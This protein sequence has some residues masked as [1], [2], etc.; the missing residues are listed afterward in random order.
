MPD[1]HRRLVPALAVVVLTLVACDGGRP[2]DASV[3]SSASPDA[4]SVD[5]AP[6]IAALY[7]GNAPSPEEADESDCFGDA[8]LDR[9]GGTDLEAAGIVVDGAVV[10]ALPVLDADTAT[11]WVQ[12]QHECIDFVEVSTR[13]LGAQS[14][15][16]VAAGAYADCLRAA[17]T[18]AEVDAA[19]VDTLTGAFDTEAVAALGRAQADCARSASPPD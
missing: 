16:R 11:Q 3:S 15:G 13:A 7:A 1:V 17:L 2:D 14:K 18:G 6:G 5:L 19:L 10:T 8:L 12:A 9:L 4:S